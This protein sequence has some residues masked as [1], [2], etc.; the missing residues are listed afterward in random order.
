MNFKS[1]IIQSS[2]TKLMEIFTDDRIYMIEI[3]DVM[4]HI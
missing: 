2:Q 4:K 1:S 3:F